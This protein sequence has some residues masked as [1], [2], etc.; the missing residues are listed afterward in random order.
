MQHSIIRG[1]I[2]LT[3]AGL[4]GRFISFYYKIFL[5]TAIGAEEIG[6]YQIIFPLLGCAMSICSM[7]IEAALSRYCASQRDTSAIFTAGLTLSLSLSVPITAVLALF[8]MPIAQ[9]LLFN[10]DAASLLAPMAL[11]IPL[12]CIHQCVCSFYYGMNSTKIPALSQICE[13]IARF[14]TVYIFHKH[15]LSIGIQPGAMLAVI[16]VLAGEIGACLFSI[17]A[18]YKSGLR[19]SFRNIKKNTYRIAAF[20]LPLSCNR[21]LLMLLQSGEAILIPLQLAAHGMDK[22]EALAV[23]GVLTG[24]ALSFITFPATITQSASLML[25]PATAS[26][27]SAHDESAIARYISSSI[28]VSLCM[29]IFCTGGFFFFGSHFGSIIFN[30]ELV[31]SLIQI[32]SFLCPF[33]YLNTTLTG[34]INGLGKTGVTFGCNIAG[35]AIRLLFIVKAMPVLGLYGYMLGFLLSQVLISAAYAAYLFINHRFVPDVL[36]GI[37][38]PV[39]NVSLS[40]G[41]THAIAGMSNWLSGYAIAPILVR[42]CIY[43]LTFAICSLPEYK[44]YLKELFHG[45]NKD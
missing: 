10:S 22:S 33:L 1:T 39:V 4:F 44:G 23:Y 41:F 24:M 26:A 43:S 9:H 18:A 7:G 27:Q 25:L 16:G 31:C 40:I 20:A 30:N 2:I 3:A 13:Q 35:V 19:I 12:S 34:V 28:L 45:C 42:A 37:I 6:L 21:L 17:P 11:S 29:G 5:A 8:R 15:A 32:L 36:G 38:M 14:L